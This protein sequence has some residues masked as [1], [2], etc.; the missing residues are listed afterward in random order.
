MIDALPANEI[1]VS[2]QLMTR[3][4]NVQ[5]GKIFSLSDITLYGGNHLTQGGAIFNQG[6]VI[7]D[8]TTFVRNMQ[9][10]IPRSWTSTGEMRVRQ[11][12]TYL[13]LN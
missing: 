9:G 1:I 3:L 2:G 13:R 4:F 6:I 7:L 5:T 10:T 11:G 8:N 12:T